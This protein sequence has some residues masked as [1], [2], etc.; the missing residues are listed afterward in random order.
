MQTEILKITGMTCGGCTSKVT[1]ALTAVSGVDDVNVTLSPGEATVK[2]DERQTSPNQ[3]KS[4][5]NNAGY[6]VG[7]A[8]GAQVRPAKGGCCG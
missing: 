2:Y 3:L 5:V 7:T 8:S 1:R 4:A 6:G